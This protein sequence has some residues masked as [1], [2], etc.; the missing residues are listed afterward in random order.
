[1]VIVILI[2]KKERGGHIMDDESGG[3]EQQE[4]PEFSEE[5][6][7]GGRLNDG[8]GYIHLGLGMR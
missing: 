3:Q 4:Y 6:L 8:C 2:Q 5:S 7:A 1:V